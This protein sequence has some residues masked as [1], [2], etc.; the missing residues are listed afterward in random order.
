[1]A[2]DIDAE[3]EPTRFANLALGLD[4]AVC[5][6]AG[7]VFTLTGAW[8]ADALGVDGWVATVYGVVVLMWS[9]VIT[10]FANRKV[11]RRREVD[12]VIKVNLAYV[13]AAILVAI[14]SWLT[15]AG[16][17]LVLVSAAVVLCFALV[18]F[19]ARRDLV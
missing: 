19:A 6:L 10:L 13:A 7:M 3:P 9:F 4:A 1:M 15:T 8:M 18:Q 2:T 5:N 12:L 16:R 11:A 17:V 14:P